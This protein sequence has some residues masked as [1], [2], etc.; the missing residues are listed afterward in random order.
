MIKWLGD[1]E[2]L[3]IRFERIRVQDDIFRSADLLI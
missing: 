2:L 3:D 1:P